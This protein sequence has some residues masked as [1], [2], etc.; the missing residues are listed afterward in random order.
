MADPELREKDDQ[1]VSDSDTP[2]EDYPTGL[3]LLCVVLA[4]VLAIF[5]TSLDFVSLP[6][7]GRS[8]RRPSSQPPFLASPTNSAA[9]AMSPG[10][11]HPFFW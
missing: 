7:D 2:E 10:T 5:L 6:L 4:L 8:D 1:Q 9:W 3:R 11:V